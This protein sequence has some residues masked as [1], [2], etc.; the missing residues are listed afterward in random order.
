M[1][2]FA[3]IHSVGNVILVLVINNGFGV[4]MADGVNRGLPKTLGLH[5]VWRDTWVLPF[6]AAAI[7]RSEFRSVAVSLIKCV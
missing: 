4:G 1:T 3:M 2:Y 6:P 7:R 5:R